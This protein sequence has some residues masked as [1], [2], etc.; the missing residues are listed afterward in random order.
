MLVKSLDDF[1]VGENME[2][3]DLVKVFRQVNTETRAVLNHAFYLG[4]ILIAVFL[5]GLV[6]ALV[7][8][9]YF[10]RRLVESSQT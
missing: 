7:S 9:R 3:A 4:L 5:I 8:Y 2:E 10:T 1:V 6:A